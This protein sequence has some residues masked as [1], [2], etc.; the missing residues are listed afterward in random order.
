MCELGEIEAGLAEELEKRVEDW[1]RGLL[2][3]TD[4][5][6]VAIYAR[7]HYVTIVKTEKI[8]VHTARFIQGFFPHRPWRSFQHLRA[9]LRTGN[10]VVSIINVL[11]VSSDKKRLTTA[12]RIHYSRAFHDVSGDD[13]WSWGGVFNTTLH[14]FAEILQINVHGRYAR[15]E[16]DNDGVSAG[17]PGV[18]FNLTQND[19]SNNQDIAVTY[20]LHGLQVL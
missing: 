8:F 16:K 3:N 9:G 12:R 1:I 6:E 17:Q 4:V 13:N 14:Y 2:A 11:A 7:A 15:I 18:R 10:E 20:G 19:P 5:G